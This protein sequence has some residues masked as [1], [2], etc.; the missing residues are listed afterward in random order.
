MSSL[1]N[2]PK[3]TLPDCIKIIKRRDGLHP[4]FEKA[5]VKLYGYTSDEGGIRHALT[6]ESVDPA[7]SDAKFMLVA[8]AAFVNFLWTKAA[9]LGIEIK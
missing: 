5:L 1:A 4:A 2:K 7:F 3:A 8:C 9:G 6:D